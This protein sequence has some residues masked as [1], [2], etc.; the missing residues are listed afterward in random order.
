MLVEAISS[1][2]PPAPTTD[3]TSLVRDIKRGDGPATEKLYR[4]LASLKHYVFRYTGIDHVEDVYHEV[5]VDLIAQIRRGDLR[6]P[7]RLA[8]YATVIARRR[9]LD[10]LRQRVTA[11]RTEVE[12]EPRLGLRSKAAGPEGAAIER[13]R[14]TI[15][16]R[17]LHSMPERDREVLIRFY[18]RGQ[19]ADDIT[20][21]MGL[22]PTQFRLIKTRA[23]ARL[24][25]LCQM[26]FGP[27]R[28]TV[29]RRAIPA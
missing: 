7:E 25:L 15:A 29:Q 21:E 12:I 24:T 4:E 17:I 6:E 8:G 26:R 28:P 3:W 27:A 5:I 13:E 14:M 16:R 19:E 9:A 20:A 10:A 2:R 23:K 1:S 11:R 22:T 18:A